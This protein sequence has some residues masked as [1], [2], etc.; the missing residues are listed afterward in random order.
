MHIKTLC[1]V[2][3]SDDLIRFVNLNKE[4]IDS[5]SKEF[6]KIYILNMQGLRIFKKKNNFLLKKNQKILP[7]NF[8]ILNISNTKDYIEFCKNK[9]LIV[10]INSLT[11]SIYDFKIFYLLK[12]VNAKLVMISNLSMI[13]NKIFLEI[14]LKNIFKSYQHL[15]LKGFYYVWRL[16]TI[17]NIFPK[18]DLLL[19]SNSV[20]INAFNQ[21]LSRKF[22]NTF[23]FFK[24]SLYRKII[25]INSKSF[26]LLYDIKKNKS[27]L[28]K[29]NSKHILYI[30]SPINHFDRTSREGGVDKEEM[31]NFYSNLFL[32]LNKFSNTFNKKILIS[33]HP[34]K[35]KL[36]NKEANLIKKN[37]R[38]VISKKR[39]L[40]LINDSEIVIFAF[41]SAI[42]NAVILK[43]K[44]LGIRSKFFGAHF[45]KI[46]K[47]YVDEF[48]FP[49]YDIDKKNIDLSKSKVFLKFRN[50]IKTY[51][52]YIKKKL[53]SDNSQ[54]SYMQIPKIIKRNLF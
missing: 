40:D 2:N 15:F 19:E 31:K 13:G 49:Y 54:A 30:D 8:I 51:D 7:K 35:L 21:G 32:F 52:R 3:L 5:L 24:I 34:D 26:D 29:K 10:I 50:S 6:K 4:L 45:L 17:I 47:K 53:I 43:K 22:E 46:H 39:T 14:E 9:K 1:F 28:E 36:F 42:L 18:I 23:P 16:M 11:K 38:I 37:N 12:K 25:R 41:S 33:L 48:K 44:I 27:K 20:H